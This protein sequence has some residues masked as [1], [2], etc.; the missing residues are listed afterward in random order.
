M[1]QRR[2]DV[3]SYLL[4]EDG[5]GKFTLEDGTGFILLETG[6]PVTPPS[7]QGGFVIP[8]PRRR[9]LDKR[10]RRGRLKW[11]LA[12][13]DVYAPSPRLQVAFG[14]R[15]AVLD[16]RAGQVRTTLSFVVRPARAIALYTKERSV[17]R[18][19]Q[20]RKALLAELFDRDDQ[21]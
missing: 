21:R 20:I 3:A 9:I 11:P 1:E 12:L 5:V 17:E 15:S 7:P 19:L 14:S 4:Q 13:V 10:R 2:A 8:V 6:A 18:E 16:A